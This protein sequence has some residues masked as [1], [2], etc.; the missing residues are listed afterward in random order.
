MPRPFLALDVDGPIALMGA[1]DA[2][3]VF[4]VTVDEIPLLI[5]RRLPERLQRLSAVFQIVWASSWGRRASTQIAPLVGLPAGLPYVPFRSAGRAGV[6]YKLSG[7][8]RWLKSAPSAIVDDEVGAD[9]WQWAEARPH[10]L[11]L[12][13]DPRFGLL[14]EHVE[15]LLE[16]ARAF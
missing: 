9:M 1:P 7:L 4:E 15:R 6:S 8:K 14:D 16:F 12:P 3:E 2:D 13:I 5:S 11:M 10:T